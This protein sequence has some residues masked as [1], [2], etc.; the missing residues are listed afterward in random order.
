MFYISLIFNYCSDWPLMHY[1]ML[2]FVYIQHWRGSLI[3][4]RLCLQKGLHILWN[5]AVI[6]K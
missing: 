4:M 3:G 5:V 2:S 6:R 1:V